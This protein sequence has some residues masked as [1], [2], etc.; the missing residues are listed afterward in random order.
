MM[1]FLGLVV[2]DHVRH[3]VWIV[4]NVFTDGEGS[5]RAKYNQ[6][7]REIRA[8]RR[9]LDVPV[10]AEHPQAPKTAPAQGDFKFHSRE[11]YGGGAQVEGIHSRG[12]HFSGRHQPALRRKDRRRPV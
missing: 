12:R 8:T 1:F 9:R 2:F 6:A 10:A 5:L 11:I 3:R 4:R 7:V